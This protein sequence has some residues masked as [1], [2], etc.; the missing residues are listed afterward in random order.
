MMTRWDYVLFACVLS[1]IVSAALVPKNPNPDLVRFVA[2][3][4]ATQ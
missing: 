3:V 1:L 2:Q 4:M